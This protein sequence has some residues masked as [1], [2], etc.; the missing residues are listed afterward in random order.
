VVCPSVALSVAIVS[1]AKTAE[2]IEVPF[3]MLT[4]VGP[5][6]YVLDDSLDPHG[7]G[8]FW[9]KARPIVKYK[10]YRPCAAAMRPFVKLLRPLVGSSC[11]T[12]RRVGAMGN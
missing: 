8:Q 11:H 7:N 1:R 3:G 4:G 6:N 5:R 10:D 9:G 12:R 2:P